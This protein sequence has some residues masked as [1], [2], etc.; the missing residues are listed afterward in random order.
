MLI[1]SA[2]IFDAV[3]R[4]VAQVAAEFLGDVV[5]GKNDVI[6][7]GGGRRSFCQRSEVGDRRSEVGETAHGLTRM[8]EEI[9]V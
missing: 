3:G 5:D 7:E 4:T 6:R 8:G 9:G 2:G 1:T